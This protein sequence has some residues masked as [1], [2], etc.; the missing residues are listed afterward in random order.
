MKYIFIVFLSINLLNAPILSGGF[1][2]KD[3]VKSSNVKKQTKKKNTGE[4]KKNK[5]TGLQL[6][7]GVKLYT[8]PGMNR[9]SEQRNDSLREAKMKEYDNKKGKP[10][11][12]GMK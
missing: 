4:E 10:K 7:K 12:K 3:S 1:F 9:T 5:K 6:P 8:Q 2:E 11:K